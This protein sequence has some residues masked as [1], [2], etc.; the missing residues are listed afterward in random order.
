MDNEKTP[1]LK[2][3][4]GSRLET[5]EERIA[6]E[7]KRLER[8]MKCLMGC[9]LSTFV[10]IIVLLIKYFNDCSEER[11]GIDDKPTTVSEKLPDYTLSP[12]KR[13]NCTNQ[14]PCI[15]WNCGYVR[16][17]FHRIHEECEYHDWSDWIWWIGIALF[18]WGGCLAM[19]GAKKKEGG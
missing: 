4:K 16:E 11:E 3:G 8:N 17:H 7:E 12:N 15:D 19:C 10:I 6:R 14:D 1:A 5:I 18:I 2:K 9:C 13:V